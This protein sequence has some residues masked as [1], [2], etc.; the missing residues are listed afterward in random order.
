MDQDDAL[1][2]PI[3]RLSWQLQALH[4]DFDASRS[5]NNDS[6]SDD[7]LDDAVPPPIRRQRSASVPSA[8]KTHTHAAPSSLQKSPLPL[9]P[10]RPTSKSTIRNCTDLS[11]HQPVSQFHSHSRPSDPTPKPIPSFAPPTFIPPNPVP[12]RRNPRVPFSL[13]RCSSLETIHS[14]TTTHSTQEENSQD[15]DLGDESQDEDPY[16]LDAE[17]QEVESEVEDRAGENLNQL[18]SELLFNHNGSHRGKER[19]YIFVEEQQKTA[20]SHERRPIPEV[21]Q[22]TGAATPGRKTLVHKVFHGNEEEQPQCRSVIGAHDAPE[23]TRRSSAASI[24]CSTKTHSSTDS[25]IQSIPTPTASVHSS[26]HS[27]KSPKSKVLRKLIGL[28]QDRQFEPQSLEI[29]K[30]VSIHQYSMQTNSLDSI[31]TSSSEPASDLYL[32]TPT[33]ASASTISQSSKGWKASNHDTTG[34]SEKD[35]KRCKKKGI[36]PALY[37]EMKAARKGKLISPISGNTLL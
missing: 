24:A 27:S 21:Y 9:R 7:D 6:G 14:V 17:Y 10:E 34:L 1:P 11:K 23:F 32:S 33:S 25:S 18:T 36:N 4:S 28:T 2:P 26:K 37:A 30:R 35:L 31:P 20:L 8:P 16:H 22:P 19:R 13:R 15:E 12:R 3:R 29:E 5:K